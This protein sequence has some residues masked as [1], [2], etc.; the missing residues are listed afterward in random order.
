MN[1]PSVLMRRIGWGAILFLFCVFRFWHLASGPELQ[2]DAIAYV[3]IAEGEYLPSDDVKYDSP[4]LALYIWLLARGKHWFG[5]RTIPWGIGMS[6][7]AG[8]VFTVLAALWLREIFP[9]HPFAVWTG[10]LFAACSPIMVEL[11]CSIMRESLY[12]MFIC[13]ALFSLTCAYTRR[14]TGWWIAAGVCVALAALIRAEGLEFSV[15]GI[16]LAF[17]GW[18]SAR[19]EQKA[20]WKSAFVFLASEIALLLLIGWSLAIVNQRTWLLLLRRVWR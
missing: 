11:S 6:L 14:K 8:A 20:A 19:W 16:A 15:F 2:R 17:F 12:L 1:N 3:Q 5:I 13:G 4:R 7:F 18:L 10:T 9:E